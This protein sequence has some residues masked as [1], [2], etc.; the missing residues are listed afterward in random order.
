MTL[1]ALKI[2]GLSHET[3]LGGPT[4]CTNRGVGT[5]VNSCIV[6]TVAFYYKELEQFKKRKHIF[7]TH[8]F[9][10]NGEQFFKNQ[11]LFLN[12]RFFFEILNFFKVVSH[13]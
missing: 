8:T 5:V 4:H 13:F 1:F 10:W 2:G 7:E 9:F 12:F 3:V 11:I 6:T